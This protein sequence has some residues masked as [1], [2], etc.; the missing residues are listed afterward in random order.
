MS[1]VLPRN[2]LV[3]IFDRVVREITPQTAGIH[4]YP[5]E[6]KPENELYTAYIAFSKDLHTSLSLCAELSFFIRLT[7]CMIM[8]ENVTPQ[9]VEAVA[10]EYH[11]VLCGHIVAQL[12]PTTKISARFSIPA[13]YRGR[14]HPEDFSDYITLTYLSDKNEHVQLI[15]HVPVSDRELW[16]HQ[17]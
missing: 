10:K 17:N 7:Q 14:Y 1:I 11:N 16:L 6:T 8:E 13:F 12:F 2:H 4:L 3:E 15:H 5:G 9:D